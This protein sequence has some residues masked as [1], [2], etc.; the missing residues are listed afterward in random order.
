ML[1]S[2]VNEKAQRQTCQQV[3]SSTQKY[4]QWASR[5]F[6]CRAEREPARCRNWS[7]SGLG[8]DG[9]ALAIASKVFT[10]QVSGLVSAF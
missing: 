1:Y 10:P 6:C 7:V 4:C 2:Y 9:R 8:R 5:Y 3:N